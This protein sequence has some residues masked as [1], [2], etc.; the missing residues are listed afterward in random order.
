MIFFIIMRI[1][2]TNLKIECVC[3]H[4]T[5]KKTDERK[6]DVTCSIHRYDMS[7]YRSMYATGLIHS[8]FE[9]PLKRDKKSTKRMQSIKHNTNIVL[10]E[11]SI[12]VSLAEFGATP[13]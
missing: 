7:T 13:A 2:Q 5:Q 11:I 8:F 1:K 12:Y 3:V 6:D 10:L 9:Q 4:K